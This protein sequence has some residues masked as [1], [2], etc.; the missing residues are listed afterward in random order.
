MAFK[1]LFFGAAL[2]DGPKDLSAAEFATKLVAS[3]NGR[4][5]AALAAVTME[6]PGLQVLPM[7]HAVLDLVNEE[8]LGHASAQ[9]STIERIGQLEGFVVETLVVQKSRHA[10][11]NH[12]MPYARLA[13]LCVAPRPTNETGAANALAEALLFNSGRPVMLVP[14]EYAGDASFRKITVAWDGSAR[15]ARAVGDAASLISNAE[16]VQVV[17]V[18][19]ESKGVIAGADL[20]ARLSSDCK[21][22]DLVDLPPR[23]GDIGKA[24]QQQVDKTQSNL[25]IMGA[26]AH[27]RLLEL[28]I[29]GVTKRLMQQS[30]TPL[31]LSY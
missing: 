10:L 25:L 5:T 18:A 17:C 7:A 22:V 11:I 23:E 19:E 2:E 8:R 21:R 26:Y 15:A 20:A 30:E 16:S 14:P 29:G 3:P 1:N 24:I 28:V 6:L 12:F 4:L 27:A 31:F 13:D 9:A